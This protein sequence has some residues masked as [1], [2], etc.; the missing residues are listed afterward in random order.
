MT[1]DELKSLKSSDKFHH[2][3]YRD[4]GTLWEGLWIYE[5][6]DG[7]RGFKPVGCFGK[8]SPELDAAHNEVRGSGVSLG[9]FGNG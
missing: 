7:L 4:H 3:T 1:L 5:K 8:D 9:S 2:A 6:Y